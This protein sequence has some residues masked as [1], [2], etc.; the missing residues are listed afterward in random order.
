MLTYSACAQ[1]QRKNHLKDLTLL[2][3][4]PFFY[5]LG[6][7]LISDGGRESLLF[8]PEIVDSSKCLAFAYC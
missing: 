4:I 5:T 8:S 1:L 6:M 7:P 2:T 3:E